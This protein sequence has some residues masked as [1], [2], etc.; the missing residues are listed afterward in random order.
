MFFF[1]RGVKGLC[2]GRLVT[3]CRV[4]RVGSSGG[5]SVVTDL[6]KQVLAMVDAHYRSIIIILCAVYTALYLMKPQ[7]VDY[8][9]PPSLLTT[10]PL[11]VHSHTHHTYTYVVADVVITK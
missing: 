10:P 2:G 3:K 7:S 8:L 1:Q 4:G 9:I 5:K 11:H 6:F